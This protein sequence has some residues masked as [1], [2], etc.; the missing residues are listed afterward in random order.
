MLRSLVKKIQ[1]KK[2]QGFI[3]YLE[4]NSHLCNVQTSAWLLVS[5]FDMI[6]RTSHDRLG[7]G[8]KYLLVLIIVGGITV[9]LWILPTLE[10]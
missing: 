1:K 2:I 5:N 10:G 3:L 7:I 4:K 9:I 6:N 8:I